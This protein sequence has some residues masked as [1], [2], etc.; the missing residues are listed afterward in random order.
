M[1]P[2]LILQDSLATEG[3]EEE[4]FSARQRLF[5]GREDNKSALKKKKKKDYKIKCFF[6]ELDVLTVHGK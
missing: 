4:D 5:A 1:T 3:P 6:N 2:G